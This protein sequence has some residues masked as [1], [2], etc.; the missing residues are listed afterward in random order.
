MGKTTVLK[1]VMA[2]S[3]PRVSAGSVRFGDTELTRRKPH[4]I[5]RAGIGYVPQGR[6]IFPS[7]TVDEHL[8]VVARPAPPGYEKWTRQRVFDLF[9][10]LAERR[11]HRA[12]TL[13]GGEQQMLAIARA[14]M[15]NP[16]LVLLDEP[17]EGLAPRVVR[18][19]ADIIRRLPESG[20]GVLLAEQDLGMVRR[21]ADRVYFLDRGSVAADVTSRELNERDDLLDRHLGV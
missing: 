11:R 19:V 10:R 1:A 4:Q 14:L 9:P 12:G 15:T 21:V 8:D 6:R 5:A 7:L 17:S 3:V 16:R 2:L 18:Q 13:S 20:V